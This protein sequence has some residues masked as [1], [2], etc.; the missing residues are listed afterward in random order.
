MKKI[1]FRSGHPGKR[2]LSFISS[3]LPLFFFSI[4]I[5]TSFAQAP[6]IEWQKCYG[7]SDNDF[8]E[9]SIQPTTDNGYV[10]FGRADSDDGDV[11]GQNGGGDYW[12]VK[13]NSAGD[14]LWTRCYGGSC[15]E[16]PG[17]ILQTGDGGYILGGGAFSP[18]GDVHGT[19]GIED[20]W[21]LKLDA[22]GDTLWTKCYGGSGQDE[23]FSIQQTDDGNFIL[24]CFAQSDDG[25]VKNSL[26]GVTP[27]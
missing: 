1:I 7:G 6:V 22:N 25:D 3:I 26:G 20:A 18:D 21:V 4:L 16:R 14:T 13:L 8:S 19:R 5:N 23:S 11:H 17:G 15:T 9:C 27:G 2:I 12:I 24:A 10:L